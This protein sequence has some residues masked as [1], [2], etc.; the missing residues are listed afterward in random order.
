MEKEQNFQRIKGYFE[1]KLAKIGYDGVF[2]VAGFEKVYR[3]LMPIQRSKLEDICRDQFHNLMK[4]GSIICVGIAYPE[5]VIDCIGVMSGDTIDTDTWN[6][7]AR[8]YQELNKL[9]NTISKCIADR[10]GGIPMLATMEGVAD[11]VTSVEDYYG[12]TVSHRVIAENAGLGWRGKNELIVNKNYSCTL[13]F[14]SIITDLPLT[15]GEKVET[16]CGACNACLEVCPFL[17]NKERLKNYREN[18]R[19]YIMGLM[20]LGLVDEVCGRCIKACYRD[21][22]FKDTF[23]LG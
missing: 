18:C 7:Y 5:R 13:R 8:E 10:F 11:K 2:G 9:L 14:A 6:I 16:S 22:I 15:Q 3:D 19:R 23:K 21:S 17:R 12:M 1:G 20:G 4:N